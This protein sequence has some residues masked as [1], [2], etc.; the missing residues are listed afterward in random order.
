MK[1]PHIGLLLLLVFPFALIAQPGSLSSNNKKAIQFFQD[2]LRQ[3]E[4]RRND[5]AYELLSR[6]TKEDDGFF[7]AHMLLGD[8]C[9]DLDKTDEA[10]AHYKRALEIKSDKFP[11]VYY[12]LAGAEMDAGKY[13]DAIAHLET[14]LKLSNV[15][16]ELKKKGE[17]RLENAKFAV[18]AFA[19]PV[20]FNPIN[21]GKNVNSE[22]NDYHP[23][24]TVDEGLLI[25]T[26]MRPSDEETDNGGAPVEEDFYI[27][28]KTNGEWVPS[29]P[30]G[31]PINTHRNEGAHCIS[32]D[33][34]FFFYTGCERPDGYGS[35][36]IY[37]SELQGN[38]WSNPRNLGEPLNSG[39][40]DAQPTLSPDGKTLIFT[41]KRSGGLG[42]A[43][44]WMSHKRE[45]GTWTMPENLGEVIN[46]DQ[47]EF[48]PFLHPDGRTLYFSSSGHPG[49]GKKDVFY[50]KL[51]SDGTWDKPVNLGYPINTK[52]DE[53]HMVVSPDGKRG[54][55]S[56]DREGGSGLRDIYGF[57]L[58]ES[59]R[60]AQV[61][62][63]KGKVRDEQT[64]KPVK[65]VIEVID[66]KTGELRAST[67]SD[68]ITGEFLISLPAGAK[69][70]V[71]AEAK[72]YLFY[73]GTYTLGKE[74][75]I[76]DEFAVDILLSPVIEGAKVVLN[77]VFF[78]TGKSE[79]MPESKVELNKL[80]NFLQRNPLVRIE[81]GGHT[82][83]VGNDAS[84]QLLSEQRA[85]SVSKYLVS[86]Q[87]DASRIESKG[88][89][90]TSPIATNDTEEGKALNRRTEFKVI[91]AKK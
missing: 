20:P 57:E 91:G 15:R 4:Y 62:F 77:N 25:Y 46:T 1:M 32:P 53:I 76:K 44:L 87:V 3:F 8:V 73:S 22:Y 68:P 55:F 36:D 24:L 83:A 89:G 27:T 23:S 40:W 11:P 9:T 26:R 61:T 70:A 71:N 79:L 80:I 31:P 66:V 43:D 41:S 59:A 60:P 34:K 33:G 16:P 2:G 50:S 48:G 18:Y 84:N 69:Y 88:Y 29:I 6:A 49:M 63:L 21:L 10:I 42:M 13:D 39:A 30:L 17:R 54:Y 51:K 67:T 5:A 65:S 72:G 19:H 52:E 74:L 81:I 82:D 37:V 12:N 45:N 35:C 56:S 90:E 28:R 75:T 85:Q 78:E 38:K 64:L 86:N 47:D 58:Y 7:E 14:F